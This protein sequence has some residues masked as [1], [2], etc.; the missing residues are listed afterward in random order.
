[1]PP[2]YKIRVFCAKIHQVMIQDLGF[3]AQFWPCW[4]LLVF[5]PLVCFQNMAI[6]RGFF[7]WVSMRIFSGFFACFFAGEY[8]QN[9]MY[10]N[11]T[12]IMIVHQIFPQKHLRLLILIFLPKRFLY[13][14]LAEFF[15]HS[16]TPRQSVTIFHF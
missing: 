6:L 8:Q 5:W 4:L 1:M 3:I 15:Y 10:Q 13:F 11:V 16:V 9:F 2:L 12:Q 7:C 14:W